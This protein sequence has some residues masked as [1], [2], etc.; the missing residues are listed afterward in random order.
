MRSGWWR[1]LRRKRSSGG[2][3]HGGGGG[4]DAAGGMRWLLTYADLITLLM[5]FFI[6]L[7]SI[8]QTDREKYLQLARALRAS[9]L[10]ANVSNSLVNV[11]RI[12]GDAERLLP[13]PN[14]HRLTSSAR[15]ELLDL[16]ETGQKLADALKAAGLSG[17]VAIVMAE[18]GLVVS[19]SDSVF[20]DLGRAD[21]RPESRRVLSRIAPILASMPNRILVEGH[22]DNLP[23][24]TAEFPSNWELSA[25]RAV[26]VARFLTE[27]GRIPPQRV[28]A[29]GY[30]EWRPKYPNDSEA[31]RARNRRVDLVLLR[32]SFGKADQVQ[33]VLTP[34]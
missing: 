29:T 17:Q 23:I 13:E 6:V 2:D 33:K 12:P 4:H 3:A 30:G 25:A 18:R 28:G 14:A 5:V 9:L 19:F 8:S 32:E 11:S 20:F 27:E 21:L 1:P 34:R 24:K 31:N 26:A 16:Q 10:N 7:Y 22:T 15:D